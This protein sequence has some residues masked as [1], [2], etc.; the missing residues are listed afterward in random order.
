MLIMY[1]HRQYSIDSRTLTT[2]RTVEKTGR[3]ERREENSMPIPERG[4]A[5]AD[6]K[7]RVEDSG[8]PFPER[9]VGKA[10]EKE[11]VED[12]GGRE[13]E[14][15]RLIAITDGRQTVMADLIRHPRRPREGK[16]S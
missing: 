10:G 12:N 16:D 1:L 9:A 3:K 8:M 7:E 11:R 6:R 5:K 15:S 2:K 13:E 4:L 14:S